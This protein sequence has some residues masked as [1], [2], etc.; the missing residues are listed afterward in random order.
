MIFRRLR[1]APRNW[2][3]RRL[4]AKSGLFDANWYLE[5]NPDVASSKQEPLAHYLACGGAEGRKPHPAF[6]A[7]WYLTQHPDVAASGMT[8]LVHYLRVG[9]HAGASPSPEFDAPWYLAKNADVAKAGLEPL[10]HYLRHG[11]LEG[12]RARPSNLTPKPVADAEWRALKPFALD[13]PGAEL[14]LF[15][16][17]APAGAVKPHARLHAKALRDKG[18]SVVVIAATDRLDS[19]AFEDWAGEVDGFY[20]RA[21]EGYDFAAW[22]HAAASIEGVARAGAILLVNDSVIGP[23]DGASFDR[24]VSRLRASKADLIGLTDNYEHLHHLQSYFLYSKG[25]GVQALLAMLSEVVS[26]PDKEDVIDAYEITLLERF[27]RQGLTGEALFPARSQR[28]DSVWSWREL[29]E[30]GMPYVKVQ[31]LRGIP[32]LDNSG[33]REMLAK[34]GYDPALAQATL[35][36][37]APVATVKQDAHG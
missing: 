26:F 32:N 3:D 34:R 9:V 22:A 8:P 28:N 25:P 33:W 20:A 27:R 23:I 29:I 36:I 5:S 10:G 17:H 16:T 31:A 14:A 12:R 7:A 13:L 19:P 37:T 11:R 15:V 30:D 24:T 4:I 35:D 21:N 2:R 18:F 6:D 1:L